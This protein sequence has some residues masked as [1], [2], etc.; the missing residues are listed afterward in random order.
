MHLRRQ[1]V[2]CPGAGPACTLTTLVTVR[3]P[4][5]ATRS[6]RSRTVRLGGRA[7]RLAPG[8]RSGIRTRLSRSGLRTLKR[9]G[10]LRAVVRMAVSRGEKVT[11]KNVRVR[12]IAPKR[13]TRRSGSR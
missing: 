13:R 6:S 7:V 2:A 9:R 5:R 11:R 1:R 4:A 3:L 10:R 8:G 12:L